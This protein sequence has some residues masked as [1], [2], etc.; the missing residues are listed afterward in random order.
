MNT[1]ENIRCSATLITVHE[2]RKSEMERSLEDRQSEMET[3]TLDI[4][5]KIA[6]KVESELARINSLICKKMEEIESKIDRL[7]K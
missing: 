2:D 6:D 3:K 5:K 1:K 7:V 4:E